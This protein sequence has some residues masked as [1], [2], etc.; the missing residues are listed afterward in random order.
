MG[1]G[2]SAPDNS[3][4]D[5]NAGP[6]SLINLASITPDT[7]GDGIPD[8]TIIITSARENINILPK[9][10]ALHQN[11][12][13][14]FNPTTVISYQIPLAGMVNLR[15]FDILGKEISLLVNEDK[16][17]GYYRVTFDASKFASGVYYYK[18]QA[19]DFIS[20]KKMVLVK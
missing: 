2:D 7:N 11:Y 4:I 18:I 3:D 13:N 1:G 12:P 19:G 16:H 8:P 5:G 20:V 9:D 6:D 14:P 15:V 17:P 10:F